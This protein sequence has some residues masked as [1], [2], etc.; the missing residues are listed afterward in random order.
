[1]AMPAT[2]IRTP[3]SIAKPS[4]LEILLYTP[5]AEIAGAIFDRCDPASIIALGRCNMR[6]H[7][8]WK[9]FMNY[10]WDL[11]DFLTS[12]FDDPALFRKA[13]GESDSLIAGGAARNFFDRHIDITSALDLY[14]RTAGVL[15]LAAFLLQQGYIFND[16]SHSSSDMNRAF[17]EWFN[18]LRVETESGNITPCSSILKV[19]L[20]TK[21]LMVGHA[22]LRVRTIRIHVTKSDP[23]RHVLG[24]HTSM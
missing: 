19:F 7:L 16:P 22:D 1:M 10:E 12:W 23:L 5:C 14:V 6:I 17:R 3:F 13:L 2:P 4:P 15:Q 21:C 20:F 24:F 8:L 18:N 9:W 11:N